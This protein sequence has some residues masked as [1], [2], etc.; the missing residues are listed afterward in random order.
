M[1][2]MFGAFVMV[3]A[4]A[5]APVGA[6]PVTKVISSIDL[7]RPFVTRSAWTFTATQGP[8]VDDPTGSPGEKAP[9]AITLCLSRDSGRT[10]DPAVTAVMTKLFPEDIFD[11]PHFLLDARIEALPGSRPFLWV[12][13]GSFL[14]GDSDQRVVTQALVYDRVR[15]RF[16]S[17]YHHVD[18][19][20]NNQDVR[21]VTAGPLRGDIV[22]VESP[23]GPPFTYVLTVSR[24]SA[25]G[26]F[27]PILHY[28][29]A[30][31]YGDGNGLAVIDS[32]MAN[33]ERHLG[34]WRPGLPLPLPASSCAKPHLVRMELW[35][36]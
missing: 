28:R 15:D 29:T 4:L 8:D 2:T 22:T 14:S 3:L 27:R 7:S 33:L 26:V 32:D 6:Q 30:T 17:A 25:R 31:R 16:I 12:R 13:T 20:N 35:C 23:S 36:R 10:C 11:Q 21:Y 1:K 24:M 19:H 34:L 18:G 9:G 5:A